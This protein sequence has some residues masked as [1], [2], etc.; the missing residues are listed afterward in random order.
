MLMTELYGDGTASCSIR[1]VRVHNAEYLVL[2]KECDLSYVPTT[3]HGRALRKKVSLELATA[4]LFSAIVCV[5][6]HRGGYNGR[7]TETRHSVDSIHE[8]EQGIWRFVFFVFHHGTC[9]T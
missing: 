2:I 5:V 1:D 3:I 7:G 4:F 9:G 8:W 6:D